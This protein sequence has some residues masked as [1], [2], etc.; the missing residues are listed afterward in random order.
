MGGLSYIFS[1]S[2]PP[3]ADTAPVIAVISMLVLGVAG[4]YFWQL[5]ESWFVSPLEWTLVVVGISGVSLAVFLAT[6]WQMDMSPSEAIS[7]PKLLWENSRNQ[8]VTY[9]L[10]RSMILGLGALNLG[11]GSL[12]RWSILSLKRSPINRSTRSP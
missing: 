2:F 10:S 5:S 12:V 11:I 8:Y 1:T 9:A 3:F 7:F 4:I 6:C